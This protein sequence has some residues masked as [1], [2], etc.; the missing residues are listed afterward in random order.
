MASTVEQL[1]LFGRSKLIKNRRSA[2]SDIIYSNRYGQLISI[3]QQDGKFTYSIDG[4]A[5]S[6]L[7]GTESEARK[8][9]DKGLFMKYEIGGTAVPIYKTIVGEFVPHY[10]GDGA[11]CTPQKTL[12]DAKSIAHKTMNM[13]NNADR[14]RDDPWFGLGPQ[15]RRATRKV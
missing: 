7:C 1:D 10:P 12:E 2:T 6:V 13:I 11:L 3:S 15:W 5:T 8:L 14:E 4:K 9:A